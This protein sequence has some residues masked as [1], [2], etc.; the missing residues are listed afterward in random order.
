MDKDILVALIAVGASRHNN[1]SLSFS[2]ILSLRPSV[3]SLLPPTFLSLSLFSLSTQTQK[4][5]TCMCVR[6]YIYPPSPMNFSIITCYEFIFQRKYPC[7]YAYL[8]QMFKLQTSK[9]TKP[10]NYIYCVHHSDRRAPCTLV[11]QSDAP[12]TP[13]DLARFLPEPVLVC[14]REC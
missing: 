4:H 3:R 1:F 14:G 8:W 7:M 6:V 11:H 2:H 5:Y 13:I 9:L 10:P 12:L